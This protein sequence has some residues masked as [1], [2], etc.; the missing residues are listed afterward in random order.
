MITK[1]GPS[2][3]CKLLQKRGKIEIDKSIFQ[4]TFMIKFYRQLEVVSKQKT[5][6]QIVLFMKAID[7]FYFFF[8]TILNKY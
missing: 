3:K 8:T 1:I 6:C 5:H 4:A 2:T 7:I